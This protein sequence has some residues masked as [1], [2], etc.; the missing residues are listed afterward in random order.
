M[1][2]LSSLDVKFIKGIGPKKA[3]LL[4]AELGI[5]SAADLLRNYP[6]HYID[7]SKCYTVSDLVGEMPYAQI[8]GRFVTMNVVGEGAKTRL[9]ALFS[10]GKRS[11]EVVWFRKIKN[12]RESI[13]LG[14]EYI[15]FGKPTR[16]GPIWQMAHPEIDVPNTAG[17]RE[18]FRGIYPL[19]E[20]LRSRGFTSRNFYVWVQNALEGRSITDPMPASVVMS[21]SLMPLDKAIRQIHMPE[22]PELLEKAKYRLKF[23]ELFYIL[24]L[25]ISSW[26]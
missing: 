3:E 25:T 14:Q 2:H 8:R 16:Y 23:D 15:L 1:N 21:R 13:R 20:R 6:N 4:T 12:I 26:I 17:A 19:T 7:R 5:S 22:S 10:D 9:T 18:G 11:M 24:F